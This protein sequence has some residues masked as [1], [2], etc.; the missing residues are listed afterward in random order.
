MEGL[1]V[2]RS[3]SLNSFRHAS[4]VFP[5]CIHTSVQ[6]VGLVVVAVVM[7]MMEMF[8]CLCELILA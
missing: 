3:T 2:E 4:K 5:N 6:S 1:D 7:M 8:M